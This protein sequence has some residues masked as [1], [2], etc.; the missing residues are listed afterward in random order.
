MPPWT[1]RR[2]SVV[3]FLAAGFLFVAVGWFS[4]VQMQALREAR[5]LVIQTLVVREEI[6][7]VLSLLKDAETSQRGFLITIDDQYLAPY[8]TALRHLPTRIARRIHRPAAQ[9]AHE[10]LRRRMTTRAGTRAEPARRC[11]DVFLDR[12]SAAEKI[13]S[14]F[15]MSSDSFVLAADKNRISLTTF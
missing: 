8:H 7:I 5:D 10:A 3:A 15:D 2:L 4:I 12:R 1:A 9:G 14:R 6:E 11:K 13:L